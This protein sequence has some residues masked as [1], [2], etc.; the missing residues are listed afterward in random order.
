MKATTMSVAY[1]SNDPPFLTSPRHTCAGHDALLSGMPLLDSQPNIAWMSK[2]DEVGHNASL[3]RT[4][5]SSRAFL[6]RYE[7]PASIAQK[8]F[9]I[10]VPALGSKSSSCQVDFRHESLHSLTNE[11]LAMQSASYSIARALHD[12]SIPSCRSEALC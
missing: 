10:S 3:Q 9:R 4:E 8:D 12:G 1:S 5:S 11:S 2:Q 7:R 6:I